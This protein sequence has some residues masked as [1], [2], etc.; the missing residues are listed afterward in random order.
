[1]ELDILH[2]TTSHKAEDNRIYFCEAVTLHKLYKVEVCGLSPRK[3]TPRSVPMAEVPNGNILSRL[4]FAYKYIKKRKPKVVHLHDPE[5]IFVGL[6][7][8][9]FLG[10]KVVYDVHEDYELK[11]VTYKGLGKVEAKLWWWVEKNISKTFNGI[12]CAD[13]HIE[14]KFK[15]CKHTLMIG[16]FPPVSL[17]EEK[18]IESQNKDDAFKVC[19]VGTIHELRGLKVA[20]AAIDAVADDRNVE[21]HI[22]GDCNN[23]D[24]LRLFN[25][26]SR[27]IYH[28]RIPWDQLHGQMKNFDLGLALFQPVPAFTYYPGENVVKLFEYGA[29]GIPYLISDFP[30]LKQFVKTN[31]GGL[32][33]N[34]TDVKNIAKT[35]EHLQD[36]ACHYIKLS[37]EGTNMVKTKFN[38]EAQESGLLSFY[39]KILS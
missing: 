4:A 10:I 3:N 31:G 12:I 34:P 5:M 9:I 22:V 30:K 17:A 23:E 39:N 20:C 25:N 32:A 37:K 29:L 18:T 26:S 24:L 36:D 15:S 14:Q 7:V 6:M 8:R 2:I 13:S 1:M 33:L 27:V 35:I 16:N 21:L 11:F 28:G 19:Y 38:W